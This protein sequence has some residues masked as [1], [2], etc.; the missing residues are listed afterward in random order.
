M[1]ESLFYLAMGGLDASIQNS[2]AAANN[3]ANRATIGYKAEQPAFQ[4]EPLYGDGAADQVAVSGGQSRTDF[5]QGPIEE[6]GRNLD[7][8]ISGPGWIAVQAPD[9]SIALT[10]NGA[11]SVSPLG[12]LQTSDGRPVLGRGMAPIALPPLQKVT[13]GQ[14]GTISGVLK[15]QTPD[16]VATLNRIALTNPPTAALQRRGDGMFQDTAGTPQQSTAVRLQSGALEG[17]NTEPMSLMLSMIENTRTFQM[18]TE[19]MRNVLN[20]DQGQGSVLTL[21]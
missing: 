9:G 18:Q 21:S 5:S 17:S 16:Q 15:G 4:A 14:D 19:M 3:L 12:I 20:T 1:S 11:L 8:A 13:I 6:T 2:T 10:R 7:V